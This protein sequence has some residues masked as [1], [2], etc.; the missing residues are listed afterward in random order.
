MA[1]ARA[2]CC[3]RLGLALGELDKLTDGKAHITESQKM[4]KFN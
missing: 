2:L 3:C 4:G 1:E